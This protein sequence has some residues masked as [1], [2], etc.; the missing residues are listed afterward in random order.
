MNKNEDYMTVLKQFG[1]KS[2]G[3]DESDSEDQDD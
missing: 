3:E 2:A 1:E